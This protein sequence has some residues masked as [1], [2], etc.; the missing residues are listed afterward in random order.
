[1]ESPPIQIATRPAVISLMTQLAAL[2]RFR[3]RLQFVISSDD[4]NVKPMQSMIEMPSSGS[5]PGSPGAYIGGS[6]MD[7]KPDSRPTLLPR[8]TLLKMGVGVAAVAVGGPYLASHDVLAAMPAPSSVAD[9]N[10]PFMAE[11]TGITDHVLALRTNAG[12]RVSGLMHGFPPGF[13]PRV[14]DLV[15]VAKRDGTGRPMPPTP[16]GQLSSAPACRPASFLSDPATDPQLIAGPLSTWRRGVPAV[17]LDGGLTIQG[18]ALVES[19]AVREA[20]MKGQAIAIA[21]LDSTLDSLLVLGTR[22]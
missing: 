7:S 12:Q 13:T 8:R 10:F 19:A 18:V 4:L 1:M 9:R 17:K 16:S 14:G 21:T 2:T 15:G 6:R 22:A 11:I 5:L 20:A 3:D